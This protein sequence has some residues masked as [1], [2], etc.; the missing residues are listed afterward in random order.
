VSVKTV[1]PAG[2]TDITDP[3][4]ITPPPAMTVGA[5]ND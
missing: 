2:V 3:V 4:G 1:C 5:T